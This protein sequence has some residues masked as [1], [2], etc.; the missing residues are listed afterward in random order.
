MQVMQ[1]GFTRHGVTSQV[2]SG[3]TAL[4]CAYTASY[5][6]RRSWDFATYLSQAQIDVQRDGRQ[7]ATAHYHLRNKGG[8]ALNKW[9]GTR[10]K[11]LP[12][13]DELLA[14]LKAGG[15]SAVVAVVPSEASAVQVANADAPAQ[16]ELA[17]RLANLKDAYDAALVSR[18]EYDARRKELIDAL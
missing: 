1:E 12:V 2:I 8:L 7:I 18:E 4:G 14:K 13:I 5:T 3:D 9:A 17:T 10:S 11:I 15:G 16:G 6:A